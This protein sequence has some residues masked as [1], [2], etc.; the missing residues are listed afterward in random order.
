MPEQRRA[1]A[2]QRMQRQLF[3][4]SAVRAYVERWLDARGVPWQRHGGGAL[5]VCEAWKRRLNLEL[6]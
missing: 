1:R 5:R 3:A 4:P 6:L 2:E